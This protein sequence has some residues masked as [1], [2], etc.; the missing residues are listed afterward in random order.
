MK[1]IIGRSSVVINASAENVW[2][3]L[4][5]PEMIKEYFF[6]TNVETNWKEG[7][8]IRFSGRYNGNEYYD[9]G[10]ILQVVKNKLL[11]YSYWGSMSG[12]EDKPE[13]YATITY[14]ISEEN[15]QTLLVV[16]QENISSEEM[17]EHSEENWKTVLTNLK[18]LLENKTVTPLGL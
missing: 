5:D 6:G 7:S 18:Q 4:T 17:K 14:R 2:E 13:N 11:K 3:S 12:I 15:G 1:N 9:K 16:T 8:P 10:T